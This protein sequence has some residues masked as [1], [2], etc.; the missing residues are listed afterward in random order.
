MLAKLQAR[1]KAIA[2]E[3]DIL[4][5]KDALSAEEMASMETLTAESETVETQIKSLER[6]EQIRSRSA[7]PAHTSLDNNGQASVPATVKDDF[8]AAEKIGY[9]AVA[10]VKAKQDG[11]TSPR[12]VMKVLDDAGYGFLARE[13]DVKAKALN[14]SSQTAGGI[15]V[16]DEISNEIVEL[17]RPVSTFL[18]GDP[19]RVT[20]DRG[21][22]HLP[23][24]ASGAIAY[25]RGEG[26]RIPPSQPTFKDI[27]LSA[28]LLGSLV[29]ITEQLLRW[30]RVDIR[31]WVEGDMAMA[32]ATEVDRAAYFG[33]GTVNQPQGILNIK[34]V[35]EVVAS[36]GANP[37]VANIE[38]DASKLEL[39]QM[40]TNL[41]QNRLAWVM[42][43]RTMIFLQNL[44]DGNGNRYFPELQLTTPTFRNKPVL[45]TTTF[46]VNMGV[47]TDESVVALI[48]FG[49]VFY[50][51][52]RALSFAVSNEATYINNQGN[53]VSA[54]QNEL[55]LIR[56]TTEVDVGL[57]YL[58]AVQKLTGVR[59]GA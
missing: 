16:P 1:L 42:S 14:A 3:L 47:G 10:V 52:S 24:A 5:Q 6:A 25:W 30:S 23:A 57:R 58:Q 39:N 48:N 49:D 59:W 34:G 7:Q 56:A 19:R 51:E 33:S 11:A 43:P 40:M 13:F 17:L 22:F 2:G 15:F 37:T 18:R 26:Q 8:T 29:P 35:G 44:R 12:A 36:G 27:N 31:N 55:M 9:M 45:L 21:N 53:T 20:F 4:L 32:M 54:F 41:P 46:G 28:K 50:G 38:T